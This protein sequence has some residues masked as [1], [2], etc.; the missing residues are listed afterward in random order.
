MVKPAPRSASDARRPMSKSRRW[1]TELD[2]IERHARHLALS[3]KTTAV[4]Q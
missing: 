1:D 4:G 3:H 2:A